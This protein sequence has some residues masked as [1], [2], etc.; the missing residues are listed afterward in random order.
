M[1]VKEIKRKLEVYDRLIK[2]SYDSLLGY[3]VPS[4]RRIEVT[5]S[6]CERINRIREE[7]AKQIGRKNERIR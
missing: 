2:D 6:Y 1:S 5:T 3:P 7:Y 4:K